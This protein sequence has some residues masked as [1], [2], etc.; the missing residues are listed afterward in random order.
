MKTILVAIS[1]IVIGTV[2]SF[3]ATLTAAQSNFFEKNIRPALVQYCYDCHSVETGKTRGG[4]LLD[5]RDGML[6]GG[7]NGNVLEGTTYRDSM[8]WAAIN[9]MDNLE[10]PP[11][12]KMPADLIRN[13][14]LWLE[15]GAP[16]P[17][18]RET[19]VVE[20]KVDI[21]TGRDHWA[22]QPPVSVP[23]AT[24]DS[25]VAAK[26]SETGLTPN[27]PADATTLLRRLNFD[28]V[29]LPPT[30]DEVKKFVAAWNR[31]KQ[32]AIEAKVDELLALPQYGER[33]GRHW[34]DVARYAE[35]TG[36]DVNVTYP[37]AWRYR[38]YV[39]D[40][41]NADKPYNE[42]VREQIAGDLIPVNS[43]AEWQENLIATGFLAIGTK[44]LN[45]PNPRQFQAEVVDEQIDTLSQA[46]LGLTISCARCHDHKYDA[47]PQADYYSLAGIFQS[48]TVYFGTTRSA[49][50]KRATVLLELP[51]ADPILAKNRVSNAEI[52]QLQQQRQQ[53]VQAR[54]EARNNPSAPVTA[55][56]VFQS[57]IAQIDAKLAE[58]GDGGV[59]LTQA[60]AVQDSKTTGDAYL[61]VRGDVEKPAQ[62]VKRG[63]PQVLPGGGPATIK[64]GHSGRLELADWLADESN[65]L[66]ARVMVNRIW[67]NLFGEGI[68]RSPNNWGVT[69]QAPTHPELLDQLAVQFMREG[70]SIKSM[71]RSIVLSETYQR[72]SLVNLANYERDP[73]NKYL[74]RANP[75]QL[76]AE[77]LRDAIL[78]ASGGLTKGRPYASQVAEFGDNRVGIFGQDNM[79]S[80]VR[81][82]SVYLPIL[83]DDLP[84]ALGLFDFADP[85]ASKPERESTNVPA[86]GLYLLNDE[87]VLREAA[88][89]AKGLVQQFPDT[90]SRVRYAFLRAYG[91]QPDPADVAAAQ[92]FFRNFQGTAYRG[93]T[94]GRDNLRQRFLQAS[95]EGRRGMRPGGQQGTGGR[96]AGMQ[97]GRPGLQQGMGGGRPGMQGGMMGGNIMG[98]EPPGTKAEI[99]AMTAEEQEMA[100]FCQALMASAE[101]R[102]LN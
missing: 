24:I 8:F 25:L 40:A 53:L 9:W 26:L 29:G 99:P 84:E 101:F 83:R 18:I 32:A 72:D 93:S 90:E 58:I 49:Q 12:E 19:V 51:I 21:E 16:D 6:L 35:S 71:V 81:Y 97:G 88:T 57:R 64:A 85:S 30:P 68:V 22:F 1:A 14:Q 96:R 42:F 13:F 65:P 50:N 82:R 94:S 63:F 3:A 102:L 23:G 74:W 69:G 91:R 79:S 47:I 76:D 15:M 56:P 36:K 48:T 75:R 54:R 62:S 55:G 77:A 80:N 100:A 78:A 59:P 41:F 60:M 95:A 52:E 10:M 20:S 17:R 61:L 39:I 44:G 27:G 37:S 73:E 67:L 87:F 33:W 46:F 92:A 4:L 28:L 7:D 11:K 2:P 38:D 31:D 43:D 98:I 70:W 66:T 45:E 89:F 86:Q 5:T 34:L